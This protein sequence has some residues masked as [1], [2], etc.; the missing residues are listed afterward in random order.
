MR[1]AE[2]L[3]A[4]SAEDAEV[5]H[6]AKIKWMV[7]VTFVS[8]NVAVEKYCEVLSVSGRA[9]LQHSLFFLK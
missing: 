2:S 7:K 8:T 3:Q 6:S 9:A 5:C 4:G 1:Q